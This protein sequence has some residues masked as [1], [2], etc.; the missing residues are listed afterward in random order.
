MVP[1]LKDGSPLGRNEHHRFL[2]SCAPWCRNV[3]A[4]ECSILTNLRDWVSGAAC[5]L[6]L[7]T[8]GGLGHSKI[9]VVLARIRPNSRLCQ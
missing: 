3:A 6:D 9:T 5:N 8:N 4:E 7:P 1:A 2:A